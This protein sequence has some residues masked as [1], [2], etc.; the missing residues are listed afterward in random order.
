[1]KSPFAEI[2]ILPA[3]LVSF[4]AS[5]LM[6]PTSSSWKAAI[7]ASWLLLMVDA[8]STDEGIEAID[9]KPLI[10]VASCNG[11]VSPP[12]ANA[13]NIPIPPAHTPDRQQT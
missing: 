12:R 10:L 9:A 1:M 3:P 6:G 7:G 8:S 5:P 4:V 11:D 2:V 13:L